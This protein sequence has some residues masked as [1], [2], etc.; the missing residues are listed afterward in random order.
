M[1]GKHHAILLESKS[2]ALIH[3]YMHVCLQTCLDMHVNDRANAGNV[4]SGKQKSPCALRGVSLTGFLQ[5]TETSLLKQSVLTQSLVTMTITLNIMC[6]E[7]RPRLLGDT[8]A[9]QG[10][11]IPT[12][13]SSCLLISLLLSLFNLGYQLPFLPAPSHSPRLSPMTCFSNLLYLEKHR[14]IPCKK[15]AY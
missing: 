5:C 1:G 15:N 13:F 4:N 10:M 11:L 2:M 7:Q 14:N 9:E 3:R 12:V 6:K 8:K